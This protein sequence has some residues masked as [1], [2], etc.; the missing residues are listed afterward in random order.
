[1]A[2]TEK[3][4]AMQADELASLHSKARRKLATILRQVCETLT[5]VRDGKT[6]SHVVDIIPHLLDPA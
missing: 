5:E 6:A 1:M 2:D 3:S 4:P